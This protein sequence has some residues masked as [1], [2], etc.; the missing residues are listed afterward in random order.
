[1]ESFTPERCAVPGAL[2][3]LGCLV[4]A[5]IDLVRRPGMVVIDREHQLR[6][7]RM[8]RLLIFQLGDRLALRVVLRWPMG[9][10]VGHQQ[11]VAIGRGHIGEAFVQWP[12]VAGRGRLYSIHV[13]DRPLGPHGDSIA[14]SPGSRQPAWPAGRK[15]KPAANP[16]T[17]WAHGLDPMERPKADPFRSHIRPLALQPKSGPYYRFRSTPHPGPWIAAEAALRGS[18][19][20]PGPTT[21]WDAPSSGNPPRPGATTTRRTGMEPPG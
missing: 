11:H 13:V 18:Q 4:L 2:C 14:S 8:A 17:G 5:P 1:M 15:A 19:P 21:K 6:L 12:L 9:L 7:V 20:R 16:S 10:A 3:H